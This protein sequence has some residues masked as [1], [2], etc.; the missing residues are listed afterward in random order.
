MHTAPDRK[1]LHLHWPFLRP[2]S[3]RPVLPCRPFERLDPQTFR[4]NESCHSWCG[5]RSDRPYH[6]L[7]TECRHAC[8]SRCDRI[9]HP[10]FLFRAPF[11]FPPI[12]R[13]PSVLYLDIALLSKPLP[14]TP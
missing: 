11:W 12:F 10:N 9:L 5:T 13:I 14:A 1:E 7:G 8:K 2:S 4:R 6:R 3:L